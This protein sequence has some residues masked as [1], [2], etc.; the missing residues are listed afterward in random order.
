MIMT[1]VNNS[2][3]NIGVGQTPDSTLV[4]D[5]NTEI[6]A[7]NPNRIAVFL[8]NIGKNNV[9]LSCDE[10]AILDKGLLLAANGGS[11]LIDSTAFSK[12]VINGICNSGKSSI[13][14][15][16]ELNK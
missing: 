11:L 16:Q 14:A 15:F 6:V 1:N 4:G 8:V 10:N 9:W 3:P 5:T 12:G 2:R 7:T 13:I